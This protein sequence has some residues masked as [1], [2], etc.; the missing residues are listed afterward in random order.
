MKTLWGLLF[1]LSAFASVAHA[2]SLKTILADRATCIGSDDSNPNTTKCN[3]AAIA[4][5]D[6]AI[7]TA[8]QKMKDDSL[9][10]TDGHGNDL[11]VGK[12]ILDKAQKAF[13]EYRAQSG[14]VAA[15]ADGGT[16]SDRALATSELK[17]KL[18]TQRLSVFESAE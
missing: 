16:G 1:V 11:S 3:N 17:L 14:T 18:T 9:T 4:R 13:V 5:A 6:A 7:G 10:G 12:P 15:I 2:D 8:I